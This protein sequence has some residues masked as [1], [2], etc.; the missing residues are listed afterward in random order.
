VNGIK[1]TNAIDPILM[2]LPLTKTAL[3]NA[4]FLQ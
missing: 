1:E 3:F 4:G 2:A